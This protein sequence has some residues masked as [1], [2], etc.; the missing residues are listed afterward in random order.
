MATSMAGKLR[1]GFIQP[2]FVW[3]F[4][5]CCVAAP[6]AEPDKDGDAKQKA[7]V[8]RLVAFIEKRDSGKRIESIRALANMGEA[9]W[10][11]VYTIMLCL[12]DKDLLVRGE[13][14]KAVRKMGPLAILCVISDLNGLDAPSCPTHSTLK[15]LGKQAVPLLLKEIEKSLK[16]GKRGMP[17][18]IPNGALRALMLLEEKAGP[19]EKDLFKLIIEDQRIA[20][21]LLEIG[22]DPEKVVGKL[23]EGLGSKARADRWVAASALGR[24]C[25]GAE[26]EVTPLAD[27]LRKEAVP[28]LAKVLGDKDKDVV[29]AAARALE[30][31]GIGSAPAVPALIR[32]L[33]HK[34][35]KVRAGVARA[36][37][38]IGPKADK[39][40]SALVDSLRDRDEQVR[41]EAARALG[42][43][44][45]WAKAA[46]PAL[47][48]LLKDKDYSARKEAVGAL[49]RIGPSAKAGIPALLRTL[50][51]DRDWQVRRSAVGALFGTGIDPAVA[52]PALMKA[53]KGGPDGVRSE[54]VWALKFLGPAA[55]KAVPLI[56]EKGLQGNSR[57]LQ[58]SSASALGT[59]GR[60]VKGVAAA[61]GRALHD[62]EAY[63]RVSAAEAL[64]TLGADARAALPDLIK[65]LDDKSLS[66]GDVRC[67]AAR[68]LGNL[69]PAAAEAKPNLERLLKSKQPGARLAAAAALCRI[70]PKTMTENLARV[71][72]VAGDEKH[73]YR[74]VAFELLPRTGAPADKVVPVLVGALNG[75]G[76][77]KRDAV[78]AL[79][80]MG[81]AAEKAVP[82]LKRIVEGPPC[83]LSVEGASAL[84]RIQPREKDLV[85][86]ALTRALQMRGDCCGL[87]RK[88][89][90][91]L[92]RMGPAAK[93]AEKLLEDRMRND[94]YLVRGG[95]R[96]ALSDIRS[97]APKKKGGAGK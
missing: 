88:A 24:L 72:K 22:A 42:L 52:V 19:A 56:I 2:L 84:Y 77:R 40:V 83:Y 1:W 11:G 87:R 67:A 48:G 9:A 96:D 45:P 74:G 47:I 85:V 43:M 70:A 90:E 81:A 37:G 79:G 71:L 61:L 41:Q 66:A 29:C 46:E 7:E 73:R 75:K 80:R 53:M 97:A 91:E 6:A 21:T 12:D 13:A 28:A 35:A 33:R 14:E 30:E 54:V 27:A 3:A 65:A 25:H 23:A 95:A 59:L 69:G 86:R 17:R 89:A 92:G 10:P 82:H 62:K 38:E 93:A 36:L 76:W 58:E 51:N 64:C 49:G 44:G 39:S 26:C 18:W 55:K 94:C 32:A 8:K 31:F 50:A 57:G 5:V 63:V 78:L 4:V 34:G 20:G 15:V 68:A 16:P 60:G